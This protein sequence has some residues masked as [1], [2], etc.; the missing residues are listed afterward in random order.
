MQNRQ[1]G[2]ARTSSLITIGIIVILLAIAFTLLPKGFSTDLTRI[3]KGSNVAVLAHSNK[4]VQ[5]LNLTSLVGKIRGDYDNKIEF[6]LVDVNTQEGRS[7]MQQQQ[8]EQ[9]GLVLF[10]PDGKQL[11]VLRDIKDEKALRAALNNYFML[12]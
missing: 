11:G 3:G 1:T 7:F 2:S 10:A 5:S 4:S 9:T 6:L 12:H 8:L